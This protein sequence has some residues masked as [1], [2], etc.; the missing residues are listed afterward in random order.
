M[1][2]G[3]RE[4]GTAILNPAKLDAERRDSI[5][6]QCHLT[7]EVRV[8]RAGRDWQ[9]FQAGGRLYDSLTVFVRSGTS[10]GM[11][12]T[13][14][15]EKLAQS[16]CKRASGDRLWCGTC[17]DPHV[18]PKP[19]ERA[20][21]FRQ[22]CLSCHDSGA[23]RETKAA[24]ARRQDDCTACHMTKNPVVDAQHVVYTD[25]SIPRRP[26]ASEAA[27]PQ[28]AGLVVF[29]G[30]RAD[31]RDIALAYAI[32]ASRTRDAAFQSRATTLL[33]EAE[34]NSPDDVEV[35][36]YLAERYRNDDQEDQAGPL[37][38]RAILLDPTQVTASV[39]LGGNHDGAGPVWGGHPSLAG[40]AYQE[41]RPGAGAH[42]HG[43]GSVA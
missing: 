32:A 22:K 19:G 11:K 1:T 3:S 26:R 30:G 39:G 16:V 6:S 34:H 35:L 41:R 36:L 9:S 23:C 28:D 13:S 12:V 31:P 18:V 15:V 21:W 4:G 29:G 40:C 7:G 25:H 10:P 20:A 37:Y 43:D 24:R 5:C 2:S 27:P 33:Q 8:M 42:Q 38:Q 17:H 14:H